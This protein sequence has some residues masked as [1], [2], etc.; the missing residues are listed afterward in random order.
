[1]NISVIIPCY[2]HGHHLARKVHELETQTLRPA[3]IIIIDDASTDNSYE[4]ALGLKSEIPIR[5]YRNT[6]NRKVPDTLNRGV[7]LSRHPYLFLTACDDQVVSWDLFEKA[8]RA[9]Q[10]YPEAGF[11]CAPSR[12]QNL[13]LGV[14]WVS[15]RM[16][17]RAR[18]VGSQEA[19]DML[20]N[21]TYSAQGQTMV[22][23]KSTF[24]LYEAAHRWHHDCIPP[25]LSAIR[26]GFLFDPEPAVVFETRAGTYSS[27]GRRT[28]EHAESIQAVVQSILSIPDLSRTLAG[29]TFLSQFGIHVLPAVRGTHLWSWDLV[30]ATL[31]FE[32]KRRLAYA[33][34]KGLIQFLHRNGF[35]A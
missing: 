30:L 35:S 8:T 24:T 3:E 16:F 14:G 12:F 34:P 17:D 32:L 9:F 27:N 21:G 26:H 25:L 4:I 19:R 33:L 22:W 29:S 10:R 18:Y 1:M 15:G 23:R 20:R 5:V 13:D 6:V 11:W 7:V 28:P 31:W 2:N